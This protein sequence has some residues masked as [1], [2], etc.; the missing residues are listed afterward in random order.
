MKKFRF[1]ALSFIFFIFQSLVVA[2]AFQ[3]PDI[4]YAPDLSELREMRRVFV[5]S[6]DLNARA[7][8]VKELHKSERLTIAERVEDSDFI[9]AFGTNIISNNAL[10]MPENALPMPETAMAGMKVTVAKEMIA[11]RFVRSKEG[12]LRPRVIWNIR[13]TKTFYSVA[14]PFRFSAA[15]AFAPKPRSAKGAGI[16]LGIRLFFF[17]LRKK[18]PQFFGFDQLNNQA[19]ISFGRDLEVKATRE[20]VKAFKR[21]DKSGA[22][23]KASTMPPGIVISPAISPAPEYQLKQP[24]LQPNQRPRLMR[25]GRRARKVGRTA[26]PCVRG[27]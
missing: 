9:L 2:Q 10:P 5:Y 27:R 24:L 8:I 17:L 7:R 13:A 21:I 4:E 14:V 19:S 25:C 22:A 3:Q 23:I 1:T 11:M 18:R 15:N 6:D 16:E 20:F 12:K 26:P